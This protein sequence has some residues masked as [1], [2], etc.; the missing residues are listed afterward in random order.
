MARY[1]PYLSLVMLLVSNHHA[2]ANF[3]V[4]S[5]PAGSGGPGF[6]NQ[7]H[8]SDP[9]SPGPDKAS[10][11]VHWKMAYGFGK[12]IPL[13]FACR[14]IVPPAVN[15]S[16]GP[17]VNPATPVSWKGGDSWNH[18]LRDTVAPLG[19]QLKMTYMAVT[20]EKKSQP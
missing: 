19:L 10:P 11:P 14:Q 17:G 13:Q 9:A 20:I 16:F 7:D 5:P 15:V 2:N 6:A 18:V 1:L 12:N 3:V 8:S 4:Q